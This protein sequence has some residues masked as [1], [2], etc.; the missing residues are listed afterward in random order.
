MKGDVRRRRPRPLSR[1]AW[2]SRRRRAAAAIAVVVGLAPA[3]TPLAAGRG[4]AGVAAGV[5]AGPAPAAS[6]YWLVGSDG[7][8]FSY[9][10]ARF[11]GSTGAITLNRPIVGMAPTPS[12]AGYWLVASDGGIFS[13]GDAA[14]FG[15]TG[16]I[17]LNPRP[18][19]G[20]A[21]TPAGAGYWLVASDGGVFS[22]GDAR[23]FGA[24][25]ASRPGAPGAFVAMVATPSG[26]GYWQAAANGDVLAFGDAAELGG[27]SGL[28]RPLVA[29][30]ALP[31]TAAVPASSGL[32]VDGSGPGADPAPGP[33]PGG[34]GGS[35][36]LPTTPLYVGPPPDF[37]SAEFEPSWGTSPSEDPNEAGRTKAGRVLAVAEAGNVVF[38]AGEFAGVTPPGVGTRTATEDPTTTL[39]RP[40]LVALDAGTGALLDWDAHPDDAVLSLAVSPDGRRL[41]VGGRFRTIGGGSAGRIAA[42][43]L[44]TGRLDPTFRPPPANTGVRAMAL[45]GDTLYVGG[46]FSKIGSE[47][48]PGLA[49][50][51]AATGALRRD[52]VPPPNTGGRYKGQT[53]TPLEDG[54]S[55]VV[56]DLA[57]TAD[58]QLIVAG[59]FLHFGNQGGLLVLD[60]TT[61]QPTTWQP[62][63]GRP[64]Y[65]VAVWPGDGT[66][67]FAA[68]G[69]TGGVVDAYRPGGSTK[70]R[71]RH[72]VD[73]DAMDVVATVKRVYLVGHYDYVLGN[74]TICRTPPCTGGNDGDIVN[75]HISAFD[76]KSGA[77][78]L[79]Y[80]PQLNTPQGPYV[81][82]LGRHHLY[83]GGDFTQV[84]GRPQPGF[85]KFPAAG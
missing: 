76:A 6:G 60:G 44:A 47:E 67:F 52:F 74:N 17:H 20:M 22:F 16:A 42:L 58:S 50:L 41:Y 19:V 83:V 71:W 9:G 53:G 40:Y 59:D 56:H 23:F 27:A 63:I 33:G 26:A 36:P 66:T 81:A 46:N 69:G 7:G 54:N 65:G 85:V 18:I 73:G 1:L 61:G 34:D 72:R 30:A 77:H 32:P 10:S 78:D 84:N 51:D 5:A 68:A 38:V 2:F 57:V 25:P 45:V 48:R 31:A 39:R 37:L 29:M 35:G 55:G 21:A 62:N 80:A 49:A 70:A 15:S 14:F 4:V 64:V 8:L 28:N 75:R 82:V 24:A 11:L 13:F 43:D 79:D 12:G 3:V